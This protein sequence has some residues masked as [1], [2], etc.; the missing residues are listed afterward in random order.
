MGV[1]ERKEREK[2][3]LRQAILEVAHEMLVK[4]GFEN[5]SMRKIAEKIEYS[6]TTIYL[7]FKDKNDLFG[8]LM[9]QYY[10]KLNQALK[11]VYDQQD[12]P[13]TSM[14]K[15]MR[16]YIECGLENPHYYKL[17]FMINPEII[18]ENYLVEGQPGTEAFFSLRR[19][20]KQCIEAGIFRPMDPDLAAQVIWTMNHGIT[21]LL[22]SN[23]NFPWVDKKLLITESI[24]RTVAGFLA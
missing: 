7:Y 16:V 13:V 10:T 24:E 22:I 3:S 2:E 11:Q 4:Q 1:K 14:K 12:D 17:G 23:P 15:G 6:P 8:L 19:S 21:S 5:I 18:K 9:E 20:V